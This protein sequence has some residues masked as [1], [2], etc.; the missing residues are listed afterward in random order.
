MDFFKKSLPALMGMLLMAGSAFGQIQQQ[1]QQQQQQQEVDIDVSDEELE[2]FVNTMQVFQEINMDMQGKAEE[3]LEEED[4]M[5]FERFQEI[6]TLQQAPQMAEDIEEPT[7][8]EE[9]LIEELQPRLEEIGQEAQEE[10]MTAVEDE[11]LSMERFQEIGQ[12]IQ[13]D[14]QMMQ[15][16]QQMMQDTSEQEGGMQ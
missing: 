13:Q 16:V 14:P 3:M 15:R 11:G 7:E 6:M 10:R 9:A 12:A 1:Q 5:D 8:E 2:Q 4:G